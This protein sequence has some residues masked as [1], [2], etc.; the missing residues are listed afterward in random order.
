MTAAIFPLLRSWTTFREPKSFAWTTNTGVV[1][2]RNV[3]LAAILAQPYDFVACL[4]ADDICYPD[5]IAK[6]VEFLDRHPEIAVVGSW[7]RFIDENSGRTLF[8]ERTPDTPDLVRRRLNS[9][10]AIVPSSSMIRADVLREV[11]PYSVHYPVAEDYELFRRIAQHYPLANI[12]SVL[13]D[14]RLSWGGLSLTR[15][16]R[17][18]FDRLM[19]QLR[20]FRALEPRAWTGLAKTLLL[21]CIPVAVIAKIK[22]Y[23]GQS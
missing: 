11:G 21:F 2:A 22:E 5:R 13:V 16:R 3:G 18:L 6:Q 19:I 17:Q 7:A 8:I 1:N 4:D 15:R 23:R 9:N 14:R 20:Y 12:P 10:A